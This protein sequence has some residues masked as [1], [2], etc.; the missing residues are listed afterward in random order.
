MFKFI[1]YHIPPFVFVNILYKQHIVQCSGG[2]CACSLS[3]VKCLTNIISLSAH[4]WA[5]T[6]PGVNT[7]L[8][9]L[10]SLLSQN[11]PIIALHCTGR[12]WL[13]HSS[14]CP[15]SLASCLIAAAT[16]LSFFYKQIAGNIRY[17]NI[18]CC[19]LQ[20]AGR[21]FL[22]LFRC[23]N[24]KTEAFFWIIEPVSFRMLTLWCSSS[25][26][27]FRVNRM[28]ERLDCS[29]SLFYFVPQENLTVKLARLGKMEKFDFTTIWCWYIYRHSEGHSGL[30]VCYLCKYL[31]LNSLI[32]PSANKH[33]APSGRPDR[34]KS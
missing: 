13:L 23:C 20:C 15:A 24:L 10:L 30:P 14:A 26:I 34:W 5:L 27:Y 19:A 31:L 28:T 16:P 12:R 18:L 17:Q 22:R 3:C 2:V 4:L 33:H 32:T 21:V 7:P 29:Q 9:F 11:G 1:T 25:T 6:R 8:T